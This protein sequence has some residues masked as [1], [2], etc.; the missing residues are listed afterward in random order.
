MACSDFV[1]Q[2]VEI[3]MYKHILQRNKTL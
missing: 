2:E 1:L 3:V